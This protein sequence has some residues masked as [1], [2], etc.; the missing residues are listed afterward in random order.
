MAAKGATPDPL[1]TMHGGRHSTRG[2]TSAL[3]LAPADSSVEHCQ[4]T[5]REDV[6]SHRDEAALRLGLRSIALSL[7]HVGSVRRAL[8]LQA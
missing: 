7:A 3:G 4:R 1:Q 2:P 8:T 5:K 6:T